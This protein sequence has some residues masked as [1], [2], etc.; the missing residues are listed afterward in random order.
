MGETQ[1]GV[2]LDPLFGAARPSTSELKVAV[3]GWQEGSAKKGLKWDFEQMVA[4]LPDK[5]VLWLDGTWEEKQERGREDLR[6]A[7]VV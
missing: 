7:K 5:S 2:R 1:E 6:L 4:T 3:Y